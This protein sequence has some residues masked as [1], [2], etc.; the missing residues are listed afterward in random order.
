MRR[1]ALLTLL[2]LGGQAGA[3]AVLE[4]RTLRLENGPQ[5]V[6][7]RTLPDTLGPLTGPLEVGDEVLI[8]AGP[9]VFTLGDGGV[10]TGRADLPGLVSA[11]DASGDVITAATELGGVTE[12]FT[13]TGRG[14]GLSVQER[15]V[16]PPD[17]AVTG[18]LSDA[19]DRVPAGEVRA[20]AQA[21]PLNPFLAVREAQAQR[22]PYLALSTVRRALNGTLPFP[23][24]VQ[25][26]ARLDRAGFPSAADLALDRARRD[27]AARG[28]DPEIMVSRT[29]LS[30]YGNPAGYVGTLLDQNRLERAGVWMTYLRDLHPRFE[31]GPALYE[32]YAQ[33]L[34]AQG[35][36]GEAGEWRQFAQS[37]RAGTLYNL[38]PQGLGAVRDAARL[39]ALALALSLLA[40]LLALSVRAWGAQ[41]EDTRALGG[42]Y[43]SWARRPVSRARRVFVAYATPSERLTMT[44]LAAALLATLGG[45]HWANVAQAQLRSPALA[46]GTYGGGWG[47]AQLDDLN[48]RPGPDAAVLTGLAAQLDGEDSLARERYTRALPD[49]CARNNLGVI[50][51]RRGDTPQARDLFRAALADRPDLMAA[52]FNLGL[53]PVAPEAAFQRAFRPG[54]A[55]LCYP[56]QRSLTRAA[57]GDL[58]V[59]L[60][61]ALGDPLRLLDGSAAGSARLGLALLAAAGLSALLVL[62]LLLPR[63]PLPLRRARPVGFRVLG[64]L[65]PGSTLLDSPWGGVLLGSWAAL[66]AALSPATGLLVFPQLPA[67]VG[68]APRGSLV[69]ALVLTYVLNT[70]AFV[71]AEVRHARR[72]RQERQGDAEQPV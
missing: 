20:A 25:L 19:A 1:A 56:D 63:T 36:E 71:T 13:L 38:G 60:R 32:R 30:A 9:A 12:R 53:N 66:V 26:A 41:G 35:R 37:L 42:R 55:R 59:T 21:D 11:L 2:T 3:T 5:L 16:L 57:T 28:V 58:S 51:Q 61:G 52:A 14:T 48:L 18:W 46:S 15:V 17:P 22:D 10:V 54:E 67:L 23:A 50:A 44:L 33:A 6:W 29:A 39:A 31:G 62:S 72:L 8:G 43:R 69:A 24:W 47:N 68:A 27:A 7:Q 40:A 4:G 45:L 34:E 49:A 64:L 70:A 65:L